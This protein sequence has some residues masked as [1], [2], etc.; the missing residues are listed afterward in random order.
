M[1]FVKCIKCGK[2]YNLHSQQKK[3]PNCKSTEHIAVTR[4]CEFCGQL[5]A[6]EGRNAARQKYCTRPHFKLCENCGQ[7]FEVKDVTMPTSACSQG[8]ANAL[9]IKKAKNTVKDRY[10]VDNISQ[11][12]V[13]RDKISKGL[14]AAQQTVIPQ[15][16]ATMLAKYGYKHCMQVPEFREQIFATNLER[17]GFT[18]PAKS[19]EVKSKISETNSSEEVR[20]KY[21]STSIEHYGTKYP[22]QCD[23][24]KDKM[25]KTCLDKYGYPYAI[26]SEDVKS[27][28]VA[29]LAS[30]R[31][32]HP[33][34]SGRADTSGNMISELNKSFSACLQNLGCKVRHEIRLEDKFY[35]IGIQGTKI[36][37]EINPTYTHNSFG[38][39]WNPQGL[40][41]NYHRNKSLLAKKHQY[42]CIHV[43]DWDDWD[44]VMCMVNP[45]KVK[46][47]ARN[48]D[49]REIDKT[50]ADTFLQTNHLQGKCRGNKVNLGLYENN[51][52]IQ[53]V[54][55]GIPRYNKQ[56]EWE[57]LRLCSKQDSIVVGGAQKLFKYFVSKWAPNSIISYC[58]VAKFSGHVYTSLGF[59]HIR[60]TEPNKVWSKGSDKITDNLLRQ[61]GFD[62]LFGTEYG[63]GTDNEVLMLEYGWLPV[64][65]CGQMVFEWSNSSQNIT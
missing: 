26:Q 50:D 31:A 6:P 18:N 65:D 51:S 13:F 57:L 61:R 54:T 41:P 30:Y 43:F 49:I 12:P 19:Q 35:D 59:T 9:K 2:E 58:D 27:K 62:S 42:S 48:L 34:T 44:K 52:L 25:K 56:Y 40:D 5:F 46:Y 14:S 24:V 3:C 36:L 15:R 20:N 55:F 38:N 29:S 1:K 17:Y 22:A 37:V 10:G 11:S 53:L 8:C 47:Y 4:V 33:E 28:M 63:K 21:M 64:Y 45:N 16:E 7:E 39:H 23:V 60:D 32:S